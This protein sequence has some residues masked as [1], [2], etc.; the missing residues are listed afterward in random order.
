M[1][2]LLPGHVPYTLGELPDDD[3]GAT[4]ATLDAM[5]KIVRQYKK[6]GRIVTLARSLLANAPGTANGKNYGDFVRLLHRFVRDSVR[7][8]QDIEGV[9]T[10]Q[11]P[12]RTL[13][14]R[15]GDCDDKGVLLASLLASIGL[16]TRFVAF[17]YNDGPFSHVI[18]E[19][20]LGTAW[21]PL[22]TIIDGAQ[23]GWVPQDARHRITATMVRN[24]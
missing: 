17:A 14:I 3:V 2:S 6:D 15:T 4:R 18:A 16:A 5:V 23:V 8:V 22:E 12:V 9:E 13:E 10:L 11:T 7:Y 24:V 20:K 1:L 21:L 19:V